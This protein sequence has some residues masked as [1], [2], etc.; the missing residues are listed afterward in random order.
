MNDEQ[1]ISDQIGRIYDAAIDPG[2]WPTVL[3]ESTTFLG[4]V[5][6][7]L[8]ARDGMSKTGMAFYEVG[9]PE[10]YGEQ[11]FSK[12]IKIDPT[13]TFQ[14]FA[15]VGVPVTILDVMP[16][17][18]FKQTRFY[19]EFVQPGGI[20]GFLGA[21]LD[22][23]IS[24]A[25]LI[26]FYGPGFA[27]FFNEQAK[28][29]LRLL[30]PHLIRAITIG[31]L[32]DK[33]SAEAT[34]F[35]GVLD[36][37]RAAM[38]LVD[39]TGRLMHANA[40]GE[41]M[42]RAGDIFQTRDG[43]LCTPDASVNN[44]FRHQF[45]SAEKGDAVLATNGLSVAIMDKHQTRYVANVLPLKNGMRQM[46]SD[47][48]HAVAAVFVQ[49]AALDTTSPPEIVAKTFKLTPS[50]LRVMLAI[51]EL[52]GVPEVAAALGSGESTVKTHLASLFTKTGSRKQADLVKIFAA[53]A[54]PTIA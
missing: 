46:S 11:Y 24:N 42:L 8:L 22:K 44:D 9:M 4:G 26:G 40:A 32:L 5:G 35:T 39:A 10:N 37:L 6:A 17:D 30:L 19:L 47:K 31:R 27:D 45:A 43:K 29:K 52:G 54:M 36:C 28:E 3:Q 20:E 1:R 14:F 50:E 48:Y 23:S 2:L 38:F 12:Y 33:S 51:V 41:I 49:K 34:T 25:A 13:N 15:E 18:E 21:I 7:A 53:Y 16:E